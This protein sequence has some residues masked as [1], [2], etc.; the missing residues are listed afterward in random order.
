VRS[1]SHAPTRHYIERRIREGKTRC[2]AVRLLKRYLA[3]HFWRLLEHTP[4]GTPPPITIGPC[5]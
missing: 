4:T 2:E 3:R 1:N 5:S